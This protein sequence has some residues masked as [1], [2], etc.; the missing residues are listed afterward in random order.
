VVIFCLSY[1]VVGKLLDQAV[2][3]SFFCLFAVT[4]GLLARLWPRCAPHS[5][6]RCFCLRAKFCLCCMATRFKPVTAEAM[7]LRYRFPKP[8]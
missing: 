8:I 6:R 4:G 3:S 7:M 2:V 1:V 5:S